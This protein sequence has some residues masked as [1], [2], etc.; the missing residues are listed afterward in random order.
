MTEIQ[1]T[2]PQNPGATDPAGSATNPQG[3]GAAN[4][5][6]PEGFELIKTEDKQNLVSARDRANQAAAEADGQSDFVL[7]LAKEREIN[8]FLKENAKD[9]PDVKMESLMHVGS[10]EEIKEEAEKLQSAIN[11]AV[12]RKLQGVE[13]VDQPPKLTDAERS[14]RVEALR[15]SGKSGSF[16]QMVD[17]RL[18]KR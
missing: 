13:I 5:E 14:E 18:N 9:F 16:G 10:P 8:T 2:D 11:D 3:G 1:N 6:I 7:T 12:A 17:L 4:G 15:N